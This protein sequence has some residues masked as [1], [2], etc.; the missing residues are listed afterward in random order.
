MPT[1]KVFV[2][3]EREPDKVTLVVADIYCAGKCL[4]HGHWATTWP[5]N[6]Q[7]VS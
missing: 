2:A 6:P 5:E 7:Q 3:R 4:V 1:L